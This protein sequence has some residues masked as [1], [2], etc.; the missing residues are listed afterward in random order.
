MYSA[1]RTAHSILV[2]DDDRTE[3]YALVRSLS[4]AGYRVAEASV[5]NH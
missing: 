2:V 3:R 5:G 1:V 4:A